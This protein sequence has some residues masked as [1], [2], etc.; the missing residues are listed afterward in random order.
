[1]LLTNWLRS[2][3]SEYRSIRRRRVQPKSFCHSSILRRSRS[4]KRHR[5]KSIESLEDRTLLTSLFS[6]DDVSVVEGNAGTSD[7]VFT[8]TRTGIS[9]GDL[10]SIATVNF[11]TLDGTATSANADYTAQSG[12]LV[13]TADPSGLNQTQTITVPVNG[14]TLT[15][16]DETFQL[17]LSASSSGTTISD[18]IGI[19]TIAN[20]DSVALSIS[21]ATAAENETLTFNVSLT[22]AAGADITFRVNTQTG[23]ADHNDYT[24]LSNQL[25]TIKAGNLS[26]SVTVYVHDDSTQESD[27]TFSVVISDP[28]LG[29]NSLPGTVTIADDTATGTI[30]NDE[31]VTGSVFSIKD[32]FITEGDDGSRNLVLRV[33]RTGGSAGDLNSAAT[34]DFTTI[35]GTATAGEDYIAQSSTISFAASATATSQYKNLFISITGDLYK[36]TTETIIARLTNPTGGSILE[37]NVATLDGLLSILND[38][39][40]FSFQGEHFADPLYA[41]HTYDNFG[42]TI[43]MDGDVMVVGVPRNSAKGDHSGAVYIYLRNQQGTPVDE[44]D[45]TWDL[46][47]ILFPDSVVTGS[48]QGTEFG[49]S[50]DIEGDTIVVGSQREGGKGVAYVFTRSGSD[51]KT[52]P[53]LVEKFDVSATFST[54]LFGASVSISQNTIVVGARSDNSGASSGGAAYIFEKNGADWSSPVISQLLADDPSSNQYYGGSV[55]ILDDL[56]VVGASN[57][58]ASSTYRGAAYVYTKN[59]ADWNTIAPT[60]TKITASDGAAYDY[61]GRSVST[62]GTEIAVAAHGA[63]NGSGSGS[64]YLYQKNGTDWTTLAPDEIEFTNHDNGKYFGISVTLSA[65]QLVV[66]EYGSAYVYNKSG[67]TW[68]LGTV[69]ES[70]LTKSTSEVSNVGTAVASTGTTVAAG[71]PIISLDGYDSGEVFVFQETN[72]GNW[73]ISSELSPEEVETAHNAGDEFGKI[74]SIDEQYMLIVAPGT[75]SALAP[76]GV[77]YVYARNDQGTPADESDD[78]WVY[79]TSFTAPDPVNTS[80]FADSVAIDGTTFLVSATLTGSIS[81]TLP[82]TLYQLEC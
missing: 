36:E 81:V 7:V 78:I 15:E 59:G 16:I 54:Y 32:T 56:I 40:N 46:E 14:D 35:D 53:P 12:T 27:E 60:E 48:D 5:L 43:A 22:E 24:F 79:E 77:L 47:T 51:W 76:A 4:A 38:D 9:A 52:Q 20:D 19:G 29:G 75:D 13:F 26:T 30:L 3:A 62:N 28:Q 8:V 71:G 80:S 74:I 64:V 2:I 33:Y 21:D 1:M 25:V 68:D 49:Y 65:S 73:I 70:V 17:L 61:F 50:V 10:N 63:H 69:S 58:S 41:N 39:T 67:A 34:V 18:N 42:S 82:P 66:G 6:V 31:S 72:P 57:D 23:T 11:T 45:D 44:S 55:S 37:G